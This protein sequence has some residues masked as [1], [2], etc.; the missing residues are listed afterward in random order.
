ME[1][2]R[3]RHVIAEALPHPVL[4]RPEG[5]IVEAEPDEQHPGLHKAPGDEDLHQPVALAVGQEVVAGDHDVVGV[6]GQAA[7]HLDDARGLPGPGEIAALHHHLRHDV[8]GLK[9]PLQQGVEVGGDDLAEAQL[10]HP[11]VDGPRHIVSVGDGPHHRAHQGVAA[12]GGPEVVRDAQG[13]LLLGQIS[14]Q[15]VAQLL[16]QGPPAREPLAAAVFAQGVHRQPRPGEEHHPA[17]GQLAAELSEGGPTLS[18]Y[19]VEIFR[20]AHDRR[21]KTASRRRVSSAAS[22]LVTMSPSP[23]PA[24]IMRWM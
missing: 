6:P 2:P 19:K 20:E 10:H 13:V 12:S 11:V 14:L 3:H 23:T 9:G 21:P 24:S 8:G 18:V 7:V 4:D 15:P 22:R 16:H 1:G 17:P 5:R